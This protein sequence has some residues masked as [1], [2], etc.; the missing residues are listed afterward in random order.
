MV[1]VRNC[2][3]QNDTRSDR[4][5][6]SIFFNVLKN[7]DT[8]LLL[9]FLGSL[10]FHDVFLY[11]QTMDITP[12]KHEL[13][14]IPDIDEDSLGSSDGG[15]NNDDGCD[16]LGVS[17]SRHDCG[18]SSS[19]GSSMEREMNEIESLAREDTNMLRVWRRVVTVIMLC[20][21]VAVLTGAIVFLKNEEEEASHDEVSQLEFFKFYQII[22]SLDSS[23]IVNL[24]CRV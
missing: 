7:A 23:L 5:H 24:L 18:Q 9:I 4:S 1:R 21:F 2:P 22:G 20:T 17:T 16:E 15:S 12:P 14:V 3:T 19:G 13:R 10:H 8:N 11:I 6:S